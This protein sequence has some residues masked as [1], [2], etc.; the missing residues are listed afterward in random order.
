MVLVHNLM[1]T[2]HQRRAGA[3][4]R[5]AAAQGWQVTLVSGGMPMA[6]FDSA[7]MRLVQLAPARVPDLAFDRLVDAAGRPV[8]DAWRATRRDA[9]LALVAAER[10]DVLVVE[11]FPFGRK[12]LRFELEPLLDGLHAQPVR[13]LLVSSIRDIVEYRAKPARYEAMADAA[14]RWFDL[15]MVHSDARLVPLQASFPPCA[16]IAHLLRYTGYVRSDE[17]APAATSSRDGEGEVLVSAGGGGYGQHLLRTA[18]AARPLCA[19]R[20][21]RWRLLVGAHAPGDALATLR[22]AAPPGVVVEAARADFPAMLARAAVSVSQGG[23]NTVLDVLAQRARAVI[24]AYHDATEREQLLRAQVL[25]SRG[26]IELLPDAE[27]SAPRLARSIERAWRLEPA[28]LDV[29]LDGARGAL[30]VLAAALS[31]R[32]A[33]GGQ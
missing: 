28:G 12:L 8:D 7:G 5:A 18:L 22:R 10:P 13:P 4:C 31:E 1:G 17:G 19:L 32:R 29:D 11:T 15:V 27:L 14:L 24:V 33:H 9:L 23:Y 25:A 21:R 30:R 20:E 2:G 26:C 3:V 6:G 16:R